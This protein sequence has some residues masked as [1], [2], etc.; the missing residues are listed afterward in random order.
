[1]SGR[2]GKRQSVWAIFAVPA[3]LAVASM[4]GLVA[5]LL[6]DG[7]YDAM[8]AAGLAVPMAG[9]LWPLARPK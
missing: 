1:M 5:G 2:R 3:V 9:L 7:V 6:G 4:A 8:A